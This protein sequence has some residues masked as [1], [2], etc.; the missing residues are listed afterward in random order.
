MLNKLTRDENNKPASSRA[1]DICQKTTPFATHQGEFTTRSSTFPVTAD[2]EGKQTSLLVAMKTSSKCQIQTTCSRSGLFELELKWIWSRRSSG[3]VVVCFVSRGFDWI[4][5]V[6]GEEAR[7]V[8]GSTSGCEICGDNN[9]LLLL[10]SRN[11][12]KLLVQLL[13]LL[14]L[15]LLVLW[16]AVLLLLLRSRRH[17]ATDQQL[18]ALTSR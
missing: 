16:V 10:N 12:L 11:T 7:W 5:R 1:A 6:D 4:F 2:A 18:T 3:R 13:V 17:K 9:R 15:L 14:L 8:Q